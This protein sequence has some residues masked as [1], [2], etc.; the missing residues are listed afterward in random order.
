MKGKKLDPDGK[1]KMKVPPTLLND[2][3][4]Y[5]NS[6]YKWLADLDRKAPMQT[7]DVRTY[8]KGKHHSHCHP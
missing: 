2:R 5:A 8:A 1:D 3:R 6:N 4:I 7:W